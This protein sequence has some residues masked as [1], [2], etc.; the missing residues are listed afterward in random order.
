M[1]TKLF[2][3][4]AAVLLALTGCTDPAEQDG[5]GT[6]QVSVPGRAVDGPLAFANVFVDLNEN[7]KLEAFEPRAVT[8]RNG[9]FGT[10]GLAS[11]SPGF[12]SYCGL[13]ATDALSQH[14]LELPDVGEEEAL[15]RVI[16]GFDTLSGTS[17]EGELTRRV[18]FGTLATGVQISPLSAIVADDVEGK[19]KAALLGTTEFDPD[20]NFIGDE[21]AEEQSIAIIAAA[22][23]ADRIITLLEEEVSN[24]PISDSDPQ[25]IAERAEEEGDLKRFN[26][27]VR[28]ALAEKVSEFSGGV[29]NPLDDDS[30][31]KAAL[32]DAVCSAR[33]RIAG[34]TS[35]TPG[36][37]ATQRSAQFTDRAGHVGSVRELVS[38]IEASNTADKTNQKSSVSA[39][40]LAYFYQAS[41]VIVRKA[42]AGRDPAEIDRAVIKLQ[43]SELSKAIQ[44]LD[45]LDLDALITNT[46]TGTAEEIAEAAKIKSNAVQFDE[47]TLAATGLIFLEETETEGTVTE[48]EQFAM[49]FDVG[50]DAGDDSGTVTLCAHIKE[51]DTSNSA[52]NEDE[53]LLLG[54]NFE[55]VSNNAM[56]MSLEVLGTRQTAVFK[57]IRDSGQ[58]DSDFI[59]GNVYRFNFGGELS[60]VIGPDATAYSGDVPTVSVEASAKPGECSCEAFFRDDNTCL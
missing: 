45:D 58:E 29:V 41:E 51:T 34:D 16:G 53:T 6:P 25:T 7:G 33:E 23:Q 42:L 5:G 56:V 55:L 4:S 46:F 44:L 26:Q 9:Y 60:E 43:D 18:D 49:I 40:V 28:K 15:I 35:C 31:I 1:N 27:I 10:N 8:D 32:A 30:T 38:G 24:T 19:L 48:E 17:F 37:V 39:S 52:N 3:I 59:D 14:C 22:I 57:S 21:N 12:V 2:A 36:T 47:S 11:G 13:A 54:G 20:A 50:S